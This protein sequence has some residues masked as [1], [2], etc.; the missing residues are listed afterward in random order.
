MPACP[1]GQRCAPLWKPYYSGNK[2]HMNPL[3]I[4]CPGSPHKN[5]LPR[6][7]TH[8]PPQTKKFWGKGMGVRGKDFPRISPPSLRS[9]RTAPF[10]KG[11]FPF[12]RLFLPLS[13]APYW[14]KDMPAL[15]VL[16]R[17]SAA[18]STR[19]GPWAR[20]SS[21]VMGANGQTAAASM[22]CSKMAS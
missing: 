7:R 4:L 11:G 10:P 15:R 20:Q 3:S 22:P 1:R 18:F 16:H 9:G 19:D 12:P 8:P 21:R 13:P 14:H 5:T 17:R 2:R 6:R